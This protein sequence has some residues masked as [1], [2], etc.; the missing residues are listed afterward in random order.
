M[1]LRS[2]LTRPVDAEAYFTANAKRQ[3]KCGITPEKTLAGNR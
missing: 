2:K 1:G 3:R